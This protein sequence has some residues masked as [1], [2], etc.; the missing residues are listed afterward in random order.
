MPDVTLYA[1]S[2]ACGALRS[3][4]FKNEENMG[5][6]RAAGACT[7]LGGLLVALGTNNEIIATQVRTVVCYFPPDADRTMIK[8]LLTRF[9]FY[10]FC[11]RHAGL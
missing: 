7:T 5:R 11:Y 8:S 4:A 9:S 3:L 1:I 2:K 10:P 6:L